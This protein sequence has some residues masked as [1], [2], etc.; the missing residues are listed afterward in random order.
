MKSYLVRLAPAP[1]LPSKIV[2]IVRSFRD[3]ALELDNP[4]PAEPLIFL[5]APSSLLASGGTVVLPRQSERV[6]FSS[7][8]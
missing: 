7:D 5:K 6:D 4:V 8:C 3:H 2:G 1:A